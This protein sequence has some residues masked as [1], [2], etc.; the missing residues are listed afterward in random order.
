MPIK[1]CDERINYLQEKIN[2]WK[3]YR[4]VMGMMETLFEGE[5]GETVFSDAPQLDN[6]KNMENSILCLKTEKLIYIAHRAN[7]PNKTIFPLLLAKYDDLMNVSYDI[8]GNMV[9]N[10]L[11]PEVEYLNYCKES[12]EQREYI[13][14]L[15]DV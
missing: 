8:S 2:K 12:L 11:I 6:I 7:N 15:C 9:R 3:P 13:R 10:G 5:E 1:D 4:T 14:K